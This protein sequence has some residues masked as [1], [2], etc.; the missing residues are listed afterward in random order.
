M[1]AT[2]MSTLAYGSKTKNKK[3]MRYSITIQYACY[4]MTRRIDSY[5]IQIKDDDM[6]CTEIKLKLEVDYE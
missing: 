6:K 1:K 3:K 4:R 2:I 5:C